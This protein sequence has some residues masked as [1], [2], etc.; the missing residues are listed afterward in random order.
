MMLSEGLK[1][2]TPPSLR[3]QSGRFGGSDA[4][5]GIQRVMADK[6][7]KEKGKKVPPMR[8]V[9]KHAKLKTCK[10]TLLTTIAKCFVW[11]GCQA[12]MGRREK[13]R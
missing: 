6:E 9:Q 3:G 1:D 11:K 13:H 2:R 5:A 4:P 10:C 7:M 8:H 12:W